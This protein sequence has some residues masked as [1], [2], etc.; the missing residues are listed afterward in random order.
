MSG[1]QSTPLRIP[2]QWSATWF[3]TFVAEVMAK[4][5]VRNAVGVGIT[6]ESDGNSVATLTAG[7]DGGLLEH[8]GDPAA[9]ANVI[10]LHTA[11][12][13]P[14]TQYLTRTDFEA[15]MA[16][17]YAIQYDQDADPPTVAYLG[18]ALPGTSAGAASWR[19]QKLTFSGDGDVSSQWADGDSNFDNVWTDRA[20]LSYS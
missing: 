15:E 6:I 16:Q 13:N 18:Q 8:D 4:A 12:S 11:N 19:I 2:D 9:H 17:Q 1:I 5:D 10:A 3:R 20:S 7:G 14:H